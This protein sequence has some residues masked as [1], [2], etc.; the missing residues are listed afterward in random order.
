M[1]RSDLTLSEW[2]KPLRRWQAEANRSW[3]ERLPASELWVATPG[4][5]KTTAAAR[6]AHALLRRGSVSTVIIVVPRDH[7]KAQFARALAEVGIHLDYAFSNGSP[8]LSHDM[9]GIV[10][11]Y[12]QV[13]MDPSIY[14]K[15]HG[16]PTLVIFDEIHHA[17][18]DASWG[19]ALQVA[20]GD[21]LYRL[22]LSGTPFRSDGQMIPFVQYR[23]DGVCQ[24]GYTYGYDAALADGVCRQIVFPIVQGEQT[25]I[26]RHGD[27]IS[28]SFTD[29]IPKSLQSERLRTH[30]LHENFAEVIARAH[31][32]LCR[33]RLEGHADAG[34]LIVCMSQEH[35]KKMVRLVSRTVGIT[36]TLVVSEDPD[37]SKKIDAFS[38]SKD[39]W[40]VAVHMV[41][42]GVDVPRLRVGVFASNVR[43]ELYFRQFCGRFV[44]LS[45]GMSPSQK[46]YVF[47]PGDPK[48]VAFARHIRTEVQAALKKRKE[49]EEEERL[50]A[51]RGERPA[52]LYAVVDATIEMGATL[53]GVLPTHADPSLTP[54]QVGSDEPEARPSLS[55]A[56]AKV[57]VR[58]EIRALV[59]V[60]CGRF[61]IEPQKVYLTLKKRCGDKD[62]SESTL[63]HLEDRVRHLKRWLEKGYYDGRR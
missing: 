50:A 44:R 4:S 39:P 16:R 43:T 58:R 46:A 60:V 11:S 27:Q 21:A 6:L 26:N 41:S 63:A 35:A 56:E 14:A 53:Y 3:V 51:I 23:S 9:H 57:Q 42:E 7:L 48:L 1:I 45:K 38:R 19:K 30:L 22:A 18:D 13:A 31:E 62:I 40:L 33:V 12:Q 20:F 49:R 17:G 29:K 32:T 61:G 47:I 8:Y 54:P 25:W 55:R 15:M 34:G 24:P 36:P 5:G 2:R 10:V 37:A 28:A 52:S 59:G